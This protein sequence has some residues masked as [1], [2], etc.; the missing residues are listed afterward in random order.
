MPRGIYECTWDDG[1]N[2]TAECS[3]VLFAMFREYVET[4]SW[5]EYYGIMVTA[6]GM[7][8]ES[9]KTMSMIYNGCWYVSRVLDDGVMS[10]LIGGEQSLDVVVCGRQDLYY[11][12]ADCWPCV[13]AGNEVEFECSLLVYGSTG[14]ANESHSWSAVKLLYR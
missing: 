6:D 11:N 9:L 12:G 2:I 3:L 13:A 5:D 14:V 1:T 8:S 10:R 7:Y 4:T